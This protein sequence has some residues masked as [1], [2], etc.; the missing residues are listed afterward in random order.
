MNS[1]SEADRAEASWGSV[2]SALGGAPALDADAVERLRRALPGAHELPRLPRPA[3]LEQVKAKRF[4]L[5]Y[6]APTARL[7][8][9]IS[10][11]R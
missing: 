1:R 7:I 6:L 3:D 2:S 5:V 4:D 11:P 10:C 9:P 8:E